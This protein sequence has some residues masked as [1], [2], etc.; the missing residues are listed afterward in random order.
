MAASRSGDQRDQGLQG[1]QGDQGDQGDQGES[2]DRVAPGWLRGHVLR[3]RGYRMAGPRPPRLS[4][5]SA[6]VTLLL[7]WGDPLHITDGLNRAGPSSVWPAMI[8]GIQTAPVLAGYLGPGH[9]VEVDFTPLGAHRCMRI[10][11]HHLARAVIEPDEVMGAGWTTRLTEQLAAAPNW[12]RR[13][14]ILD[15]LL[16]RQLASGPPASPLITEVW[17]LICTRD[18]GVT[19]RELTHTTGRGS[20]RIQGLFREHVGIPP[21]TVSRILRFHRTLAIASSGCPSL[22]QLAAL[23]GYH[24]QAHMSREFRALSGHTPQQLCGLVKQ[25]SGS[26]HGDR[27]QRFSD[28]FLRERE[29]S[30]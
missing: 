4:L 23:G 17:D 14:A 9:A 20:R 21:Q 10:P 25:E 22:A 6:T 5:P 27:T 29:G 1:H 8:A 16:A 11:L 13:W 7:G 2:I 26:R 28:F 15:S 18:G 3:Y 24:D 30:G 12:P 19:L